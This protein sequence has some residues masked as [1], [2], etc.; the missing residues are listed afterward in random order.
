MI[1]WSFEGDIISDNNEATYKNPYGALSNW[2]AVNTGKLCPTGWHIPT[3]EEWYTLNDFL[4]GE[5]VAGGKLKEAGAIHWA[6]LN[7]DAINESGFTA[8]PGGWRRSDNGT[9]DYIGLHGYYW[10]SPWNVL[11]SC[12]CREIISFTVLLLQTFTMRRLGFLSV[13]SKIINQVKKCS[14]FSHRSC[15]AKYIVYDMQRKSHSSLIG[16]CE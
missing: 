6:S 7:T 14:D 16:M 12:W 2:Y 9:F 8:R 11:H 13:V 3:D 10:I 15:I 4:G 1:I 5:S